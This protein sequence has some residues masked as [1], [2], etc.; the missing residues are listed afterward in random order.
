MFPTSTTRISGRI[1]KRRQSDGAAGRLHDDV[2]AGI[3]RRLPRD[4]PVGQRG[5]IGERAERHVGEKMRVALHRLPQAVA[6]ALRIETLDGAIPAGQ[7]HRP[8]R[9]RRS[10]VDRVADRLAGARIDIVVHPTSLTCPLAAEYAIGTAAVAA[11]VMGADRCGAR[12][13]QRRSIGPATVSF[14]IITSSSG[15]LASPQ[16]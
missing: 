1:A 8:R 16:W 13:G 14:M 7:P 10:G 15:M 9:Q 11:A 4:Q 12:T 6:V 5:R 3:A 2:E